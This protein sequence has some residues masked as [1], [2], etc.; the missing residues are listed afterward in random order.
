MGEIMGIGMTFPILISEAGVDIRLRAIPYRPFRRWR[1]YQGRADHPWSAAVE[2]GRSPLPETTAISSK[3]NRK[4]GRGHFFQVTGL[5][6][7]IPGTGSGT[8]PSVLCHRFSRLFSPLLQPSSLPPLPSLL[9]AIFDRGALH[10]PL[11]Q[12]IKE[13]HL[14]ETAGQGDVQHAPLPIPQ[15]PARSL[16]TQLID[17][18]AEAVTRMLLELPGESRPTQ[19]GYF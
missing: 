7:R 13:G 2:R 1:T 3:G 10:L 15:L 5:G 8:L 6:H 19:A 14:S 11:E 9:S 4:I 17:E 16:Q 18:S 12:A